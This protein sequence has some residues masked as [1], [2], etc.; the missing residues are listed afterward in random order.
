[1]TY[2]AIGEFRFDYFQMILCEGY[3]MTL[4]NI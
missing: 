4:N 2:T 3:L 1:M